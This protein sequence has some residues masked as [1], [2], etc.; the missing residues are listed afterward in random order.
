MILPSKFHPLGNFVHLSTVLTAIPRQ[1][2]PYHLV[3]PTNAGVS[4]Q[5]TLFVKYFSILPAKSIFGKHGATWQC[6]HGRSTCTI[7]NDP[8]FDPSKLFPLRPLPLPLSTFPTPYIRVILTSKHDSIHGR[9]PR[10]SETSIGPQSAWR[11]N[12]ASRW[13]YRRG[14]MMSAIPISSNRLMSS[15][16]SRKKSGRQT[17]KIPRSSRKFTIF[18]LTWL[19]GAAE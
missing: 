10:L 14:L 13:R 2:P 8:V 12:S 19:D 11:I 16:L 7:S 15:R 17:R 5:S 18:L 6:N 9:W 1:G 4:I 3:I